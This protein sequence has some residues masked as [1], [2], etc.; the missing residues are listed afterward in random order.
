MAALAAS[1]HLTATIFKKSLIM[2]AEYGNRLFSP[3]DRRRA[4]CVQS[5]LN[6]RVK[7]LY[8]EGL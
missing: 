3:L 4:Q 5:S 6:N 7:D 8:I 2:I 1:I